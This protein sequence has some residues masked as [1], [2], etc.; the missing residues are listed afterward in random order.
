MP[1]N[2]DITIFHK[3]LNAKTN[4]YEYK[5]IYYRFVNWQ[6][7]LGASYNKGYE[8]ANDVNIYIPK[9]ANDIKDV[10][11]YDFKIGD[12]ICK[13]D[14]KEK[15]VK[16]SDLKKYVQVYNIKTIIARD[17]GSENIQHIEIG[18]K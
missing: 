7:G 17:L 6:G 11:I 13:G 5:R 9:V 8:Q 4:L 1:T 3:E 16:E 14:I 18:A 10:N 2:T 12:I 15:I